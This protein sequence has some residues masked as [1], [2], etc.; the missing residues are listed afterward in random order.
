MTLVQTLARTTS[1]DAW[2]AAVAL[3]GE[4]DIANADEVRA[5]LVDHLDAGRRVLRVDASGVTFADAA[6]LGM[7]VDAHQRCRERHGTMI[8][9]G[10]SA[11]LRRTIA[12]AGL[13]TVLLVDTAA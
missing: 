13:D 4:L 5:V 1:H 6:A 3:E 8:L 10:S 9:V 7:L 2:R 11:R 12:L